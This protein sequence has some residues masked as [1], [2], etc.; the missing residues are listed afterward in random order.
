MESS[1]TGLADLRVRIF[2]DGADK[3]G[4][5]EMYANS[6]IRGFTTIPTLMR[7]ANVADYRAF[8]LDVLAA[9]QDRPISF[10]VFADVP[11]EMDRQAR[12]IAGWGDNVYVKIPV[13]NTAGIP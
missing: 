9:I 11:D 2:A 3:T 10:D 1:M 6:L 12:E 8:A 13:T 4:M 5:L 7:K